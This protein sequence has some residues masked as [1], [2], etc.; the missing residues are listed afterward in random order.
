MFSN[1]ISRFRLYRLI[2]KL[3]WRRLECRYFA[4][5]AVRRDEYITLLMD[6]VGG[7]LLEN[8]I[9]FSEI[10]C[11]IQN[12]PGYALNDYGVRTSDIC[13]EAPICVAIYV[14]NQPI[15]G[16]ALEFRGPVICIRQLQGSKGTHLPE[17][18]KIWPILFVD[19]VKTFLL[20]APEINSMRLYSA[21]TRI[22]YEFPEGRMTLKEFARYQQNLRRRYDGTARQSGFKKK[23][24]KR[25]WE[26]DISLHRSTEKGGK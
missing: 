8:K 5:V 6:C 2:I 17:D 7:V 25:Y 10:G 23:D 9:N 13:W 19:S 1:L 16:M 11:H 3:K 21:D 15:L 26:W 12:L 24:G 22:S 18:L 14:N 20:N 4:A